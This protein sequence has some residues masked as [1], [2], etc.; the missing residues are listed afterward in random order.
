MCTTSI[1][2]IRPI[3]Q[4]NEVLS[5]T[6]EETQE[7]CSKRYVN[8]QYETH[9]INMHAST[10]FK[11]AKQVKTTY[12]ILYILVFHILNLQMFLLGKGKVGQVKE[13]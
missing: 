4:E 2:T 3:E 11:N 13:V 1:E 9:L 12:T 6:Y 10:L 5:N 8:N 7:Q